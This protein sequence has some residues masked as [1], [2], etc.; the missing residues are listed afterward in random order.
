MECPNCKYQN[1]PGEAFC[2][3]CGMEL[4]P[5]GPLTAGTVTVGGTAG[6]SGGTCRS[7]TVGTPLQGRRYVITKIRGEG[8]MG[9]AMLA[10][11]ERLD[12]KPV[13]HKERMPDNS[14][15]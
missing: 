9:A 14:I 4:K 13:V 5:P 11:D 2:V 8:G 6:G 10:T 15:R 12:N 3:N 1:S 7:L